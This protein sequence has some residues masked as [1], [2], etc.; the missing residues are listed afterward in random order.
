VTKQLIY[1]HR[2]RLL[3]IEQRKKFLKSCS[4]TIFILTLMCCNKPAD[5]FFGES[6]LKDCELELSMN[7]ERAKRQIMNL[8]K[9]YKDIELVM[10]TRS[11]DADTIR[12]N[13]CFLEKGIIINT[14]SIGTRLVTP[15]YD[16]QGHKIAWVP[17]WYANLENISMYTSD[18][19][20][21]ILDVNK[22]LNTH[23][24][25]EDE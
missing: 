20:F 12:Y 25:N 7:E 9:R 17:F 16:H 21:E 10:V 18:C 2:Y 13:R 19:F 8:A 11:E 22:E 23:Y 24:I 1:M 5:S 14:V 3:D 15:F 6:L 4:I